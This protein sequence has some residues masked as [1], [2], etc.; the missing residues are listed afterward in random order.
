MKLVSLNLYRCIVYKPLKAFVLEQAKDTDIFCFQEMMSCPKRD[1]KYIDGQPHLDFLEELQ[2]ELTDFNVFYAPMQ[3]DYETESDYVGQSSFGLSILARKSMPIAE[4]GSFF[5]LNSF[6][7]FVPG[8]Y[9]TLGHNVIYIKTSLGDRPLLICSVHGVSEPANKEDSPNR[10]KQ[11][12]KI[13]DF[14]TQHDGETIIMGDFNLNPDTKSVKMFEEAGYRNLIKKFDI[15]NTRG[16]LVKKLFPEYEHGPYGFQP[17]ADYAFVT[18]GINVES[19][20]VPD[21]PISDHLPMVL[22]IGD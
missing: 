2:E 10:L 15:K 16:S 1:A 13:L 11:S 7:S 9:A 19:F 5:I 12:Q 18:P 3:E 22:V 17:Y 6:N 4:H 8:D 14:T 20:E 21:V